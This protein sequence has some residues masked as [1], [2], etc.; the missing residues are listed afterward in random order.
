MHL[1]ETGDVTEALKAL[2]RT[3]D[4]CGTAAQESESYIAVVRMAV[5]LRNYAQVS[6]FTSKALSRRDAIAGPKEEA[7][8]VWIVAIFALTQAAKV[9]CVVGQH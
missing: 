3:R 5:E 8:R 2:V 9:L 7:V 1:Y 4:Y 6:Q